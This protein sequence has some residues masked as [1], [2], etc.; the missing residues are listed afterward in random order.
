MPGQSQISLLGDDSKKLTSIVEEMGMPPYR[1]RQLFEAIYRQR[2]GSL[3]EIST[4]P[5]EL[6]EGM[7]S[8]GYT[9]VLPTVKKRFVSTDGTVRYL[10]D[11]AD[12]E[13]VVAVWM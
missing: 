13:S 1:A 9:I 4:L 5:K 2:V 12:G 11:F 10:F 3:D 7:S 6:R 8:A